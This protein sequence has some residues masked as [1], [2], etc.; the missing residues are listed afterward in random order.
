MGGRVSIDEII[1]NSSYQV[2]EIKVVITQLPNKDYSHLLYLSDK[3]REKLS[4]CIVFL[5]SPR[6]EGF[7]FV[8]AISKELEVRGF[9]CKDF[10]S[11]YKEI[12]NLK[13]GGRVSVCQGVFKDSNFSSF[14]DRLILVLEE[15]LSCV[16]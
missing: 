13:G 16:F 5:S 3:L 11:K 2:K 9:S 4:S 8:L 10:I 14:K 7:I 6:K 1:S 12:L 15:F